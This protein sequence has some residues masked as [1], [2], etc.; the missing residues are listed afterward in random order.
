MQHMNP[1]LTNSYFVNQN[2]NKIPQKNK[3]KNSK[4]LVE[5]YYLKKH[6]KPSIRNQNEI[7]IM[8]GLRDNSILNLKY[9]S[10]QQNEYL[11]IYD[12]SQNL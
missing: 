5:G 12:R 3:Y 8:H 1:V 10:G 6:R 2:G 9:T 4:S 7:Q 11:K